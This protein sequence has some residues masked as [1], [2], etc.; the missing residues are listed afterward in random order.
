MISPLLNNHLFFM[1]HAREK[2]E[3]RLGEKLFLKGDRCM[4]PKCAMA[5]RAY[6]PG[7]HGKS[8]G[9]GRGARGGS[10]FGLLLKEKQ[11]IHFFY[12]IDDREIKQYSEKA[13]AKRGLFSDTLLR[14]LESRLD[15]AFW[16]MGFSESRRAARQAI[17]HG[18]V[19]VNKKTVRS[20]SYSVRKNDEVTLKEEAWRGGLSAGAL[21]RI[22]HHD[23][24]KWVSMDK[25]KKIATVVG[26]PQAQDVGM[27]FDVTKIKEFYSR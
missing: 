21:E 10:E 26:A 15:T 17:T 5:R 8:R 20:P 12:G 11:K 22:K 19:T 4:G 24:P 9:K 3:R 18:H 1:P 27:T 2:V 7:V 23:A 16:R 6:P 25:E 14:M 13:S